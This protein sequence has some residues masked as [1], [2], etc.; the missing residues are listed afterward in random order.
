MFTPSANQPV[1]CTYQGAFSP[2]TRGHQDAG[3]ILARRLLSL[4]PDTDITL[5]YM[6]TANVASKDSLSYAKASASGA[7]PSDYVSEAERFELLAIICNELNEEPEFTRVHFEPSDVEYKNKVKGTSTIHTLRTLKT[8]HPTHRLVLAMGED[9]G[10]Q[11]AWWTD[12]AKYPELI[13]RMLFVDRVLTPAETTAAA[14]SMTVSDL[15]FAYTYPG[16]TQTNMRFSSG[17]PITLNDVKGPYTFT[18]IMASPDTTIQTALTE[19]AGK[20]DLLEPPLATEPAVSSSGLRAALRSG[21][22]EEARRIAG[23]LYP[24]IKD[25]G[26]LTRTKGEVADMIVAG[27]LKRRNTRRRRSN[28]RRNTRRRNTRQRR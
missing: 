23:A 13:E 7:G 6:P 8:L 5:F 26:L 4:Y 17:W 14:A 21:N 9:N 16:A 1:I 12:V 28:R 11:L 10:N 3:R 2:P 19:L 18:E 25:K 27:S 24:I 22:E 20:T 15:P